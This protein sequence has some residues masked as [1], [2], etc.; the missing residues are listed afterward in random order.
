MLQAHWSYK[1]NLLLQKGATEALMAASLHQKQIVAQMMSSNPEDAIAL[2]LAASIEAYG[3]QLE[4]INAWTEGGSAVLEPMMYQAIL[5]DGVDGTEY[6]DIM[7][8][9]VIDLLLHEE[10]WG[11]ILIAAMMCTLHR[12]LS[13]LAVVCMRHIAS[14]TIIHRK[15]SLIGF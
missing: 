1:Q 13:I 4:S 15:R 2:S 14:M 11:W 12:S 3:Q 6:E 8:L 10:E 9:L 5:K 7:Q